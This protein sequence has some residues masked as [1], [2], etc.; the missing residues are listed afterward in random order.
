MKKQSQSTKVKFASGENI[1]LELHKVRVVQ[2]LNLVPIERR[3][4]AIRE[5]G[6]NTFQLSTRDVFLDMLTD[7][8]TNA[9]S[10]RQVAA[11]NHAD[12]AYAGSQSFDRFKEAVAKVFGKKYLL[13][14]HQGRAAENILAK[15]FIKQDSIL[16]MNYH[17]TTTLAH[18]MLNGGKV[19]EIL[20]DDAIQIKS[21]NPFKGNIDIKKLE[22]VIAENGVEKIP[23]IRMEASTNLIGGQPFSI[24]NMREVRKVADKNGLIVVLDASLIG[25]N[26][27]FIKHR[28]EEFKDASV[29]DIIL[30]MCDLAD[31]VYFSARKVTSSRGGGICT[32]DEK[33]YKIM[34]PLIPVYEGF[35]TYGGISVREIEAL[36]VGMMETIDETVISQSP[37]FIEYLV[38]QLELHGIPVVTPA[39]GLGCHVD[40]MGFLPH[41]PQTEYPAGALAAAFYLV[42]GVRG[43]ERGTISS[44]RDEN[45]NDILADVELLRLAM[46][47]RVFTLSQVKYVEDR[48]RWLYKNRDLV[49]GLKFVSEPPVLR[50]FDGRLEATSDWPEKLMKKFREDFGDSL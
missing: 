40:A 34:K 35:F 3:L 1:P 36:A 26:A 25:E 17:F 42:S 10:D 20:C 4:E 47:R 16:P 15:A 12:D 14:A 2:K 23:F 38:E 19:I 33:L 13:P 22:K 49:G 43:M 46:P 30:A 45:G 18:I 39:G 21:K 24:A 50:F 5:A 48:L 7:S 27:Y 28:E 9:M 6:F 37:S 44:I 8:G 32:N 11:M 41:V 31:I 29:G